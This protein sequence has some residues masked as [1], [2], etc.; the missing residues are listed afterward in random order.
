MAQPNF[1]APGSPE[2]TALTG[3]VSSLYSGDGA[4]KRAER[5]AML[6]NRKLDRQIKLNAIAEHARKRAAEEQAS[7]DQANWLSN[8]IRSRLPASADAVMEY[9]NAGGVVQPQPET[10]DQPGIVG[11][12][13]MERP[14]GYTP[15]L[16]KLIND[17]AMLVPFSKALPGKTNAEQAMNARGAI[18]QQGLTSD[19]ISGAIDPKIVALANAATKGTLPYKE[20]AFGG[21]LDQYI[22]AQNQSSPM[23][24]AKIAETTAQAAERGAHQRLYDAQRGAVLPNVTMEGPGGV[25]FPVS[26]ADVSRNLTALLF[27]KPEAQPKPRQDYQWNKDRSAMELIP[28]SD[29]ARKL[30]DKAKVEQQKKQILDSTIDAEIRNIDKLIGADDGSVGQH[31]GLRRATGPIN[32]RLPTLF[33]DTANAEALIKSLQSKASISSLQTIRSTSG[34]VGTLT[35]R[36]WP[37]L[38]SMKA[39]L[40]ES[41]GTPQFIESLKEYRN[42]LRRIK[43]VAAEDVAREEATAS[44]A[45]PSGPPPGAATATNPSTGQRVYKDPQTGEWFPY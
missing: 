30:R 40:Q 10:A 18:Q 17:M 45:P 15:D 24:V 2:S 35:E 34:A 13:P 3:L 29:T 26:G 6:E 21:T 41:Q 27:P 42:E 16:E 22:G 4:A 9:R 36:E 11:G 25:T 37:R 33:T 7:R 44:A 32:V 8:M 19:M 12:Y 14:A 5:E 31:P 39:T 38:E 20:N 23:A 1:F 28:G 43:R